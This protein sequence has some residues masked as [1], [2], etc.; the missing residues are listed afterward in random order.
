MIRE[1]ATTMNWPIREVLDDGTTLTLRP[2]HR[3]DVWKTAAALA[4]IAEDGDSYVGTEH[5]NIGHTADRYLIT[6]RK[7]RYLYLVANI[8][9]Q[10]AGLASA[11]PG[12][13]GKKDRH[14]ATLSI[15]LLPWARGR[16]AGTTMMTTLLDWCEEVGYKKAELGVFST[17]EPALRLYQR[18]GFNVEVRQRNAIKLPNGDYADNLIMGRFF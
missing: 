9:G 7:A 18:L 13:F 6:M 5:V 10:F 3:R 17:N 1:V 12:D 15:W 8:D 14:V 4:R 2:L 16:G 11:R